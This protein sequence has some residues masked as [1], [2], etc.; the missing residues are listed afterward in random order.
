MRGS[1]LDTTVLESIA[2]N[3]ARRRPDRASSTSRWVI[4]PAC[5]AAAGAAV[6]GTAWD[7]M[8]FRVERAGAAGRRTAGLTES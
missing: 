8:A 4:A 7:T 2:T 5:S 3:M 6:V 1:A